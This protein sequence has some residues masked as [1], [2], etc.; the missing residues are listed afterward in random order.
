MMLYSTYYA[1]R[2]AL[3]LLYWYSFVTYTR[4]DR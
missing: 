1:N 3:L 2:T 4:L